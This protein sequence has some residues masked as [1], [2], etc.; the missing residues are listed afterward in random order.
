MIWYLGIILTG[1][2]CL[3]LYVT[4]LQKYSFGGFAGPV[5]M[6]F[7]WK[8]IQACCLGLKCSFCYSHPSPNNLATSWVC[9]RE[10]VCPMPRELNRISS[11]WNGKEK[12]NEALGNCM[13][14]FKQ[15]LGM[16][17]K[18]KYPTSSNSQLKK[19]AGG[20]G[21]LHGGFCLSISS[22]SAW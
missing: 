4:C 15:L 16:K 21:S 3:S 13:L 20:S 11:Q 1:P 19:Q 10:D 6:A 14:L 8:F 5:N 17:A 9:C 22:N 18:P 12:E 7:S 2:I